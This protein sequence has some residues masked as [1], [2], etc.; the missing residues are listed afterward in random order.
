MPPTTTHVPLARSL[1]SIIIII[2]TTHSIITNTETTNIFYKQAETME[3]QEVIVGRLEEIR[4]QLQNLKKDR[5]TFLKSSDVHEMFKELKEQVRKVVAIPN[6]ERTE[7]LNG[8]MHDVFQLMSLA[9]LTVGLNR[10]APAN[11]AVLATL[12]RLLEHLDEAST[13][14][15]ADIEPIRQRLKEVRS[16]LQ[17]SREDDSEDYFTS[18]EIIQFIEQKLAYCENLLSRVEQGVLSL[19]SESLKT[20]LQK[21]VLLRREILSVVARSNFNSHQLKPLKEQLAKLQ[22]DLSNDEANYKGGDKVT[23]DKLT[24]MCQKLLDEYSSKNK[25]D[26]IDDSLKAI[27]NQLVELKGT[28]ENLLVTH[29]WTL[30][31]TDLYFY[32]KKLLEFDNMRHNGSFWTNI[33]DKDSQEKPPKGQIVLLYLIRRCYGI[34]YKLLEYSEPVSEALTPIHNQLSTVRQCLLDVKNMGGLSS[35][36]ELYPYQMKLASIDQLRSEGKFM[37]GDTIPEGQGMLNSLLSECFDICHELKVDMTENGD[38]DDDDDDAEEG[39]E[40]EQQDSEN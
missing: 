35:T 8:C 31:E 32:Q 38:D 34:I 3:N 6:D 14:T 2:I 36:R 24:A 27:Y 17:K 20:T 23:L 18:M 25:D 4:G 10:T 11:Y 5:S 19:K 1:S 29:R 30:R 33:D 26:I 16:I 15:D 13:Y 28:L 40:E 22:K 12:Q 37:V 9:L 21:L 7:K 39:G